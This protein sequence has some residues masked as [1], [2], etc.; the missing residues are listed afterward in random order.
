LAAGEGI[1]WQEIPCCTERS[2]GGT[3]ELHK[4]PSNSLNPTDPTYQDKR[5]SLLYNKTK[6]LVKKQKLGYRDSSDI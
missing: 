4:V 1:S 2:S 5:K 3:I 6:A